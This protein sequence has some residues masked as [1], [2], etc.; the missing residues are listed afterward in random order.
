MK[1]A[2]IPTFGPLQGVKVVHSSISIAGPFCAQLMADMGADVIWIENPKAPD[3]ARG[4]GFHQGW[5][6]E[7]NRRN[8]RSLALAIPAPEGREVFL[9]LMKETDIFI[10]AS[11]GGQYEKWGL[12]DEALW[13]VN[14]RLI[15]VHISGFGQKG[16]PAYTSRASYDPIAQA[17]GGLMYV[18]SV[19]GLSPF[20][21]SQDVGDI[22]SGY[23]GAVGALAALHRVQ[24]TGKGESVD[25]AQYE[26]VLRSQGHAM[27][28]ELNTGKPISH[29]LFPNA[30]TVSGY[31]SFKCA[32]GKYC[33]LMI[34]G[35]TVFKSAMEVLGL[36]Y[37]TEEIPAGTA[38]LYHNMPGGKMIDEAVE[39][40]C[41]EHTAAEVAQIFQ[42]AKV[43]ASLVYS[44]QD[45]IDDPQFVARNSFAKYPSERYETDIIAPNVQPVLT[46]E[47]GQVWRS[48]VDSGFDN[49]D[50]LEEIGFNKEQIAHLYEEGVVAKHEDK[51]PQLERRAK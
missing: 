2:D 20:P 25:I 28:N 49:D 45:M 40:F 19:E 26:A 30:N 8:M 24:A 22:Y 36:P 21:S 16:L 12:S 4:G 7:V 37:G 50:I 32:D 13:E 29:D 38:R 43:P 51:C 33:V 14:P 44:Y 27:M 15:I 23:L 35:P 10:E 1:H 11:K 47:P 31:G 3:I 17:V 41:S 6:V 9:D 18:N 48:G 39:K 34:L 42:E 5:S 46:N